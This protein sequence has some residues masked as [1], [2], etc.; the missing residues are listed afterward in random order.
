M[1]SSYIR[2]FPSNYRFSLLKKKTNNNKVKICI[3]FISPILINEI[4]MKINHSY[5]KIYIWTLRPTVPLCSYF[6]LS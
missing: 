1:R 3:G 2:I 5:I 4:L 6:R